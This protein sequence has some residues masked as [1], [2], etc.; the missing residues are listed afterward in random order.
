MA[1]KKLDQYTGTLEA[2]QVAAGM[3]AALHLIYAR[4]GL[5]SS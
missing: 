4:V 3:N 5:P 2:A 1:A